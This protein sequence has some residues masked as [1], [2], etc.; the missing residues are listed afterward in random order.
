LNGFLCSSI[1]IHV[2]FFLLFWIEPC[3][4]FSRNYC[5]PNWLLCFPIGFVFCFEGVLM[6]SS[7]NSCGFEW[8]VVLSIGIIPTQTQPSI[9]NRKNSDWK[10]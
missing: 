9:Q 1:G 8:M 3:V 5:L 7:R 6:F 2:L 10:T 4:L